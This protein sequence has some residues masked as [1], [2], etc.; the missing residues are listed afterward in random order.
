MLDIEVF[1]IAIYWLVQ[2]E[3]ELVDT[4]VAWMFLDQLMAIHKVQ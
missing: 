3:F 2:I 1:Y 4:M